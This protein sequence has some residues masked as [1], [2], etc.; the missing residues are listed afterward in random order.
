MQ[1]YAVNRRA[2][3][4]YDILEKY[5]AGIELFGFEVKA[6]KAG[7]MNLAGAYVVIKN[8][9]AWLLNVAIAPYQVKNT[10]AGYD[11]MRSRRLLLNKAEIKELIGKSAQKGLTLV[12]LRVYDKK[13]RIKL[14]FAVARHK[15]ERDKRELIKEREA[16]R[17]IKRAMNI[18]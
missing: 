6:V 8:N 18:E 1:I 14:E 5:E 12:P 10:P 15:K 7:R 4:D 17:E 13:S 9:E 3:F 2:L 16:G 11:E